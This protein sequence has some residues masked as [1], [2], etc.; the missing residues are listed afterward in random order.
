M[1]LRYGM[2]PHQAARVVEEPG[3][4]PLRVVSGEPS[5]INLLDMMNAWQL[6]R[7]AATAKG[8]PAAT[9]FKHVSPAVWRSREMRTPLLVRRGA[10]QAGSGL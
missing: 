9:S 8:S 2:N 10:C 7:E 1:R 6:V 5:A 4:A 3:R